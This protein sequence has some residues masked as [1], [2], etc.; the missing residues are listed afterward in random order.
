MQKFEPT[1]VFNSKAIKKSFSSKRENSNV[2]NQ[3]GIAN[4]VPWKGSIFFTNMYCFFPCYV[5]FFSFIYVL[6]LV[7]IFIL[8]KKKNVVP[9]FVFE[10]FCKKVGKKFGHLEYGAQ[11]GY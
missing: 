9:V 6:G 8:A 10:F 2:L 4:F 7:E 3:G 11:T 5:I 1:V